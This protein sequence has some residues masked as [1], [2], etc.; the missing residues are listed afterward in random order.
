MLLC[1]WSVKDLITNLISVFFAFAG[2]I[3]LSTYPEL[4]Q[5]VKMFFALGPVLTITH[6]TSPFVTFAR[7]PQPVI[8]VCHSFF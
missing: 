3:A 7:L 5:R 8:H 2:F 6:A 4:A 1:I